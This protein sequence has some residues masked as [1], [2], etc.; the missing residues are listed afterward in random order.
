MTK[1]ETLKVLSVL[2]AAYPQFYA[3]Q[4]PQDLQGIVVLWSMMFA[5]HPYEVVDNAVKGVIATDTSGFPPSIGIINEMIRKLEK[6]L[7]DTS[8]DAWVLVRNAIRKSALFSKREFEA[9]PQDVQR[10]V[11]SPSQLHDWAMMPPETVDSVVASNFMRQYRAMESS[12]NE[13]AALPSNVRSAIG[14]TE[15]R[16]LND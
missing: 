5:D 9:L 1:N 2:K 4:S 16:L 14:E 13:I 3:K 11:G 8:N 15:V 12:R 10:A 6:P 7:Q